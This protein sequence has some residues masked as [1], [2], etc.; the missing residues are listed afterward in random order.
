MKKS[1]TEELSDNEIKNFKSDI[2][3]SSAVIEHVG[4]TS[5]QKKDDKE[6]SKIKQKVIYN[7][8]SK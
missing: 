1:I 8:Y 4:N 6:Y 3:I 5:N 2:V 7:N